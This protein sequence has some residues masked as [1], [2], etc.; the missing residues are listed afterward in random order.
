MVVDRNI[1][2]SR[3]PGTAVE[4]ALKLLGILFITDRVPAKI[5][6]LWHGFAEKYITFLKTFWIM[7]HQTGLGKCSLTV[8][9]RP[10]REMNHIFYVCF[11]GENRDEH[12]YRS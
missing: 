7:N 9:S 4:F 1:I 12:E 5:M 3:A 8:H 10:K 11:E 6:G 2:T